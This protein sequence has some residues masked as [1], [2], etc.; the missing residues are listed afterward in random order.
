[1][2]PCS[3]HEAVIVELRGFRAELD[4]FSLNQNENV[5]NQRDMQERVAIVEQSSK[6]SHHRL[7]NL[8]DQTKAIIRVSVSVESMAGKITEMV[9]MYKNHDDRIDKLEREP[10]DRVLRY[11]QAFVGALV[12]GAAGVLIGTFLK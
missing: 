5:K 4:K 3:K 6:S 2:D 11:W 12:T 10:G 8:E 1:M 7:D 9:D